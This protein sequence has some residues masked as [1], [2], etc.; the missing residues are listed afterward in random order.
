MLEP[1]EQVKQDVVK[2][3]TTVTKVTKGQKEGF[4]D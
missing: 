4:Q 3:S 1:S 2:K